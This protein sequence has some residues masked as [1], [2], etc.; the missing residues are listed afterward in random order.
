MQHPKTNVRSPD[1][2]WDKKKHTVFVHVPLMTGTVVSHNTG[3][4]AFED[5]P[6]SCVQ[7]DGSSNMS[8]ILSC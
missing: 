7:A 2:Y 1:L 5:N 3:I 4:P 6:A 8:S